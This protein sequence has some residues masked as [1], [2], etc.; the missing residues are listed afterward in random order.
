MFLD[1]LAWQPPT[2]PHSPE[3]GH[4]R[5]QHTNQND[6]RDLERPDGPTIGKEPTVILEAR[7]RP[8]SVC[9]NPRARARLKAFDIGFPVGPELTE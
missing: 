2:E 4:D 7:K 5:R 1:R 9:T 3:D 8:G 6:Q